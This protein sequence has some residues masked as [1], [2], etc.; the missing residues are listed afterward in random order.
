MRK[1]S[2]FWIGDREG[3]LQ[4]KLVEGH[5][6]PKVIFQGGARGLNTLMSLFALLSFSWVSRFGPKLYQYDIFFLSMDYWHSPCRSTSQ[7]K[8]RVQNSGEEIKRG[9]WE[10]S[11]TNSL[12]F[13]SDVENVIFNNK[14]FFYSSEK[15]RHDLNMN[16]AAVLEW[17][18][19]KTP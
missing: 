3:Q 11:S 16:E 12:R 14:S 2:S 4:C 7:G 9:K 10:V 8:S 18:F 6:Q 5:C 1:R 13:W 17:L 19:G 15:Y